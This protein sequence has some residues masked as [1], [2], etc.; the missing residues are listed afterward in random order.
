MWS[1]EKCIV[2]PPKANRK[3]TL[4]KDKGEFF[5]H[6]YFSYSVMLRCE[7]LNQLVGAGADLNVDVCSLGDLHDFR[8]LDGEA[9]R[10][11]QIRDR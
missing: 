1:E 4:K 8:Q 11:F 7:V 10:L 5:F 2:P 3:M 9:S 6:E